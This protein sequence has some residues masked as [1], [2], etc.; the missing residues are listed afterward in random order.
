MK[1]VKF[2]RLT[3]FGRRWFFT[4]VG[5]NGEPLAQSEAYNSAA[6]RNRGIYL[7]QHDAGNAD[8]VSK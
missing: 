7:I 6:N 1:F 8:I 3:F 5:D 2:D 4:I